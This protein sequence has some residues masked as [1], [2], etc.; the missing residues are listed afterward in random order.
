MGSAK[1][2]SSFSDES[3]YPYGQTQADVQQLKFVVEERERSEKA[4]GRS[5]SRPVANDEQRSEDARVLLKHFAN[6]KK[7]WCSMQ[8]LPLPASL[9]SS[10]VGAFAAADDV[11]PKA[12]EVVANFL[13]ASVGPVGRSLRESDRELRIVMMRGIAYLNSQ[14]NQTTRDYAGFRT[15]WMLLWPILWPILS[16]LNLMPENPVPLRVAMQKILAKSF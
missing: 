10:G 15:V 8:D 6:N 3:V 4:G 16:D 9:T 1:A 11:D 5:K 2:M 13:K 14:L 12:L 7:F